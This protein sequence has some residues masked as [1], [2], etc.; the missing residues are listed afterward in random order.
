[1]KNKVSYLISIPTII[2]I[3]DQ[4]VKF[5]IERNFPLH[6]PVE[7]VGNY[8]RITFVYNP[9]IA[10]GLNFGDN[11]PY[12]LIAI[13]ITIFVIYLAIKEVSYLSFFAYCLIIGGALGNLFDRIFRGFVVDFIDVG[14]NENLRW[15]VFNIADSVITIAIFLLIIDSF[16]KRRKEN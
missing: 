1:M 5:F 8:L 3:L 14:I 11:F 9:G 16:L 4:S 15:F 2:L 13:L 10:F 7:V 6:K 12:T